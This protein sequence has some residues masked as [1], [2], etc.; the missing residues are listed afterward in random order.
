VR[1]GGVSGSLSGKKRM[2]RSR[3]SHPIGKV[4]QGYRTRR[5][6]VHIDG[7]MDITLGNLGM[8]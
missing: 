5:V 3:A 2:E 1:V 4:T 8:L 7:G 6:T